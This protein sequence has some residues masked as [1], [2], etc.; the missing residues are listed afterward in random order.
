MLIKLP[1]IKKT[2]INDEVKV[3][4]EEITFNLDTSAYSEL[5]YEQYF[6]EQLPDKSLT[7]FV[8]R[9]SR[10]TDNEVKSNYLSV[11]KVLYCYLESDKTPTF[12]DFIK[13]FD[14]SIADELLQ[15]VQQIFKLAVS[16]AQKN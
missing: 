16:S 6:K 14:V 7:D 11:L 2:Y 4:R 5:R 9:M 15:K 1:T 12:I 10:I 13:L 3:E 8:I